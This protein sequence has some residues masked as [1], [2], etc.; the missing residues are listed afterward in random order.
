MIVKEVAEEAVVPLRDDIKRRVPDRYISLQPIK[1]A[2][3]KEQ[4]FRKL[5]GRKALALIPLDLDGYLF[6]KWED[7]KRD[8][9]T[10]RL[11]G[12]FKGWERDNEIFERGFKKVVA[13]LR[14]DESAREEPPP[15]KFGQS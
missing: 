9:V 11:A 3:K 12:D 6:E 4:G 15:P 2:S 7:G 5:K 8:E 10:S 14:S 1:K 13:A